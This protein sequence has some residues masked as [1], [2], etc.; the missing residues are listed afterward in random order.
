V[1]Y[2]FG[3][4]MVELKNCRKFTTEAHGFTRKKIGYSPQ[5]KIITVVFLERSVVKNK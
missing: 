2:D 5:A 4:R 1:I 3:Y